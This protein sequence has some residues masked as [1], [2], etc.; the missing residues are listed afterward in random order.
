VLLAGFLTF[1]STITQAQES[2]ADNGWQ[3][4]IAPYLWG[5]DTGGKTQRGLPIDV[6]IDDL[7][8]NLESAFMASFEARKN[9][10]MILAD[11]IY[12]DVAVSKQFGPLPTS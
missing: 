5:A 1:W 12:L 2:T 8:D 11:Y 3:I 4:A 9:N 6:P 10:W 7:V